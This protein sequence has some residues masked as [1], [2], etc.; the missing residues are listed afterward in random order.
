MPGRNNP[1]RGAVRRGKGMGGIRSVPGRR[2]Q[3]WGAMREKGWRPTNGSRKRFDH[4]NENLKIPSYNT[5][6]Q[7]LSVWVGWEGEAFGGRGAGTPIQRKEMVPDPPPRPPPHSSQQGKKSFGVTTPLPQ[8]AFGHPPI[9]ACGGYNPPPRPQQPIQSTPY[10]FGG[11]TSSPLAG[12]GGHSCCSGA[13]FRVPLRSLNRVEA[14]AA[15]GPSVSR[16]GP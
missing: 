7:V 3:G 4:E 16:A 5:H 1:G 2:V 8:L 11:G 12:G 13:R 6:T 15:Y 14:G 10:A 9:Q